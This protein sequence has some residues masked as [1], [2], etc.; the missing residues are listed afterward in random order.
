MFAFI[1]IEKKDWSDI[2]IYLGL[3]T[4]SYDFL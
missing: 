2:K 1:E 3:G 4:I